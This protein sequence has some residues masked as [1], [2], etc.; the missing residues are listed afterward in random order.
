ME[1]Y[2]KHLADFQQKYVPKYLE[3]VGYIKTTWLIPFKE[4]LVRA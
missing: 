4:K 1:E 2:T 3:E